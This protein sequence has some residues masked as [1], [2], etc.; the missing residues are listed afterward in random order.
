MK[1]QRL[2]WLVIWA[3]IGFSCERETDTNVVKH[4]VAFYTLE[5]QSATDLSCE[6]NLETAKEKEKV[7]ANDEILTYHATD[8]YF[9]L[10]AAAINRLK[11]I[12]TQTPF[13]L[14]VDGQ[15]VYSGFLMP[16]YL[17][18]ACLDVIV[19]DPISYTNNIIWVRYDY[20][21]R[22]KPANDFRN[23]ATLLAALQKQGKLEK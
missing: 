20:S 10:T 18:L 3:L 19:M 16:G 23:N 13:Y 5:D 14:K 6:L 2:I 7:I 11:R 1:Q 22:S 8:H 9:T 17:S 4:D 12:K 21:T 15:V